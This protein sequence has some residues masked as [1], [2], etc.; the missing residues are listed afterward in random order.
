MGDAATEVAAMPFWSKSVWL[1]A[2]DQSVRQTPGTLVTL[3]L[4][5]LA[6]FALAVAVKGLSGALKSARAAGEETRINAILSALDQVTVGPFLTVMIAT[7]TV[8]LRTHGLHLAPLPLWAKIGGVPTLLA[9]VFVGDFIGYWRHRTQHS[10]WLW[11]AHAIHHSDTALTWFSLE[12]MH[13]I[14]R[15]GSMLDTILLGA[16]G[17]PDWALI[18]NVL[19]RHYYGYFIHADVPW[20]FGKVGWVMNSPA[21]HRWHHTRDIDGSGSN[22]ATVFSVFDRLFGTYY[23]PG[24]CRAPLGVRE[25]MGKGVIGQ[26][27]YPFQVWLGMA[28]SQRPAAQFTLLSETLTSAAKD[29]NLEKPAPAAREMI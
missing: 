24:P 12:R 1:N 23:Q 15:V 3:I 29:L 22:F 17:F 7:L 26:Y 13:P 20:T 19:I 10:K 27:L 8:T 16:L 5:A 25:Y 6:F 28:P 4:S 11:P 9:T 21:M 14:D 2:L 18:G